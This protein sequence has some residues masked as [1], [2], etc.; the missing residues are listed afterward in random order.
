MCVSVH[1]SLCGDVYLLRG[2]GLCMCLSVGESL[3][4]G[5][6]SVCECV[7][8]CGRG[9]CVSACLCVGRDVSLGGDLC[10]W[11]SPWRGLSVWVCVSLW[12]LSVCG[13]VCLCGRGLCVG[14]VC[15]W[16]CVSL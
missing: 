9:L 11:V 8:L 6:G 7:S 15:V 10:V 14:C 1:V 5:V 4:I 3:C 12:K 13:C 16:V 2:E